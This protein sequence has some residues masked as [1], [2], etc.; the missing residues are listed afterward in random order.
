[1]PQ[2]NFDQSMLP[3][4]ARRRC[5]LCG[6]QIS[7]ARIEPSEDVD[8]ENARRAPMAKQLWSNSAE[9]DWPLK[10]RTSRRTN[11][12]SC[13]QT[14]HDRAERAA[15]CVTSCYQGG[16]LVARARRQCVSSLEAAGATIWLIQV[17]CPA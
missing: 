1:M 17:L 10:Q 3:P 11:C 5:P 2:P 9:R 13:T 16:H 15:S 7:L 8:C 6:L 14:S 4:I 12:F